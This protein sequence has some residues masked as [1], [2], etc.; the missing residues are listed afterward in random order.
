MANSFGLIGVRPDNVLVNWG[1]DEV[2]KKAI[3]NVALGDSDIAF[4]PEHGE[5]RETSYA[6]GDVM[7]QSPEGH[8]GRG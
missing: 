2:A 4:K 8:M 7:W 1:C 5:P 3:G 6:I